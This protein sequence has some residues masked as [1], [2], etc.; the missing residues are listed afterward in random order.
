[1]IY[2]KISSS[3]LK[4]YAKKV[5]NVLHLK[6]GVCIKDYNNL[7]VENELFLKVKDNYKIKD[8]EYYY[9]NWR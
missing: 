4:N 5:N 2:E 8:P 3:D 7:S 1:M 9:E 6:E